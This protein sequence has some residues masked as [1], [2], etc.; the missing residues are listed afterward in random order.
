MRQI[1]QS[2][3][4]GNTALVEV[5]AP[6]LK[7]GHLLIRSTHTLLSAGTERMLIDFGKSSLIG[8]ALKQPSKVKDVISKIKSDG[9]FSTINA[10]QSKLDQPIP[11]GYCNVGT[12]IAVADDISGF[13]PGD[14]VASNG[15][16]AEVVLVP[17]HL[18][19]LVPP[20]V[21]PDAACFTV[22]ASIALQSE[23]RRPA[24]HGM[25]G[26][27]KSTPCRHCTVLYCTVLYNS[28][29]CNC[30]VRLYSYCTA[31]LCVYCTRTALVLHLY[32]TYS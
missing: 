26:C 12:V 32:W 1:I 22:L 28:A 17:K 30:T 20:S 29:Y 5:P 14:L 16:H 3:S 2:L 8:K 6:S 24:W 10:V 31:V 11:L 15:P 25:G 7:S 19:A 21:S 4:D 18:C 13:K 27:G 9:V 23:P